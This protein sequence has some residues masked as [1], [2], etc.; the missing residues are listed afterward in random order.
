MI[1]SVVFIFIFYLLI[2]WIF[3]YFAFC[4]RLAHVLWKLCE[5]P[6]QSH[7]M[8]KLNLNELSDVSNLDLMN[9]FDCAIVD[10]ASDLWLSFWFWMLFS[11]F[12]S[13]L[14]TCEC[15]LEPSS[16]CTSIISCGQTMW[17]MSMLQN[18]QMTSIL[19][20]YHLRPGAVIRLWTTFACYRL[21]N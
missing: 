13:L 14:A 4:F 6:N 1:F 8:E 18:D 10:A 20:A 17:A 19:K 11:A 9:G 2:Y 5:Q 12:A 16:P 3:R 15:K 21:Q 7:P